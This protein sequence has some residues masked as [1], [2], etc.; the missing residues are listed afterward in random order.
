MKNEAV[1]RSNTMLQL[2]AALS[3]LLPAIHAAQTIDNAERC[4][5]AHRV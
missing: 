5:V 3:V 1:V 4:S 2:G